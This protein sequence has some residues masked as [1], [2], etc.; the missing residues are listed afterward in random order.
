MKYSKAL[1]LGIVLVSAAIVGCTQDANSQHAVKQN[2]PA[3]DHGHDHGPGGSH[4]PEKSKEH[5]HGTGPNG[6]VIFDMGKYHAEFTVDH[7]KQ[8]CTVLFVSGDKKD[9]TP[10]PVAATEL[11][12]TTEETK[13][14]E[15]T[16]VPKMTVT[17]LA[18]DVQ[19]GKASKFVG[20]DPGIG[21]VAD[22]SG[23]VLAEIDGKPSQGSFQE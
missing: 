8:E 3:R 7:G 23:T 14:K 5:S 15:G 9:S 18:V 20:K 11:T 6:G 22:F 10:L 19:D 16:V 4:E 1:G 13:T 12:L 2:P 17:L 21:N